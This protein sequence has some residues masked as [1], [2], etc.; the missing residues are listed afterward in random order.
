MIVLNSIFIIIYSLVAFYFVLKRRPFDVL[1]LLAASSLYYYS[2]A[3]FSEIEF[4]G[5]KNAI[6]SETYILYIVYFFLLLFSAVVFDLSVVNKRIE[7]NKPIKN[8]NTSVKFITVLTIICFSVGV[9]SILD[10]ILLVDKTL[11]AGQNT[12]LYGMS[13][14]LAVSGL[15]LAMVNNNKFIIVLFFCIILFSVYVGGRATFVFGV[16]SIILI[17]LRGNTKRITA[18]Y[19]IILFVFV[20]V[21]SLVVYKTI[22]K[23]IKSEDLDSVFSVL[24]Y[25]DLS[26]YIILVFTDPLAVVSNTNTVFLHDIQVEPGYLIHRLSSIIPGLNNIVESFLSSDYA[27]FNHLLKDAYDMDG[28]PGSSFLAELYVMAGWGG[29]VLFLF[30]YFFMVC[31]YNYRFLFQL[32]LGVLIWLPCVVMLTFYIHRLELLSIFGGIKSY[33]LIYAVF[34]LY[35][36]L[37]RPNKKV[38]CKA[39]TKL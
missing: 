11:L 35:L 20:V 5:Y 39:Y 3:L 4:F 1:T 9:Y 17:K 32:N 33:A 31:F 8:V 28:G 24:Q 13:L 25:T 16:L 15:C 26:R 14:F 36:M 23:H 38:Y 7:L 10:T 21:A 29:Y 6:M 30:L 18:H 12:F 34:F 19:K 37:L 27:V 22:Y 2:P